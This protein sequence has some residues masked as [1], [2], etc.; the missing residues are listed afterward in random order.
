MTEKAFTLLC[1][2]DGK[3]GR[4]IIPY[5][6]NP[7]HNPEAKYWE[8]MT[9][10]QRLEQ[11]QSDLTDDEISLLQSSLSSICGT[12][13]D[14]AGLFDVLRW[15]ALGGYTMDGLYETGD[16]FKIPSGQ[17][18]FARCFFEE[19]LSTHNLSYSFNTTVMSIQ[20]R[21]NSVVVNR[22]WLAKRLI[23]TI[24]LNVLQKVRFEPALSPSKIAAIRPG[25][26]NQGSKFHLEISAPALRSWACSSWP[27]TRLYHG[28]GDGLTPEGNTHLV[29]F[30]SNKYF[31]TPERDA[32][33]FV[34]DC[35][36]LHDMEVR[37]TVSHHRLVY[38]E[39][40]PIMQSSSS[41]RFGI[42]GPQTHSR[43][44]HGV[45][46][47][48]V[49]L[50]TI[51]NPFSNGLEISFLQVLTGLWVGV[52]S[53]MAQSNG[54]GWLQKR[55]LLTSALLGEKPR[56]SVLQHGPYATL[57]ASMNLMQLSIVLQVAS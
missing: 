51:S 47:H 11:I 32:R 56:S 55:F 22:A 12:D 1:N 36:K 26:V 54:A 35:K 44:A 43:K 21:G 4:K 57:V 20:D 50:S 7:H 40:S 6:H 13:M 29:C 48:P 30:G 5:P 3:S 17:S 9:V 23:C 8:E 31:V 27:P 15:W 49:L 28:A 24:P 53:L 45:C 34:A 19:A 42:T 52:D 33:N 38:K 14:K 10:A 37:K 39:V 46:S 2:V 25:H 18:N 41:A 16:Q